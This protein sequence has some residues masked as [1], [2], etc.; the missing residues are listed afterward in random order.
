MGYDT[1]FEGQF[2][3]DKPLTH[4]HWRRLSNFSQ[5]RHEEPAHPSI[6][7]DWTPTDEGD[8]IEWNG[9][10]KFYAYVPWLQYLIDH[11]LQPWGYT[12]SGSVQWQGHEM[13]DHGTIVV[14]G[15]KVS[16]TSP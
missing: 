7:C 9:T 13:G 14:E 2:D 6:W 4:A 16:T 11:F 12:L 10:E 8:G 1:R 15:D 3:L 5:E